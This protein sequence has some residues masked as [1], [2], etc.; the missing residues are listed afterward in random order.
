MP[1]RHVVYWLKTSVIGHNSFK[2][3][4]VFHIAQELGN[5][6]HAYDIIDTYTINK[7][8]YQTQQRVGNQAPLEERPIDFWANL[9]Q[10]DIKSF[11]TLDVYIRLEGMNLSY[12]LNSFSLWHLDF[13][14]LFSC[15]LYLAKTS[16]LFYGILGI[17][18]LFFVFLYLIE[19]ELIYI[20]FSVFGLG[21]FL[22]RAF[23]EFNFSSYVPFPSLVQYNE[24][25]F[26]LS[27]Y[28]TVLGGLF[29]L[30]QYLSIPRNGILI[31]RVIPIYLVMTLT[32]YLCFIFRYSFSEVGSFPMLLTPAPYTF[33]GIFLGMYMVFI[34]PSS[35]KKS[36]IWILLAILPAILGGFLILLNNDAHLTV[37]LPDEWLPNFINKQVIDDILRLGVILLVVTIS[38]NVGYRSLTLKSE[39]EAAIQE[40]LKAQKTIF[41]KQMRTEKLEEMNDLKTRLYTNITH[42]FRTPLTVIMGINDELTE[43]TQKLALPSGKKEKMLQNQQLI[44]RNSE[45]LLNLVNQLLD[46]SKSDS[47]QLELQ[48]IQ[49]NIIPFLNYLTE[50]FFSKAKEKNIRLV[51]YTELSSLMM[52]YDEVKV[53]HLVYN[54]LSNALKFTRENGKIVMHAALIEAKGQSLL[55]LKVKDDGIGIPVDKLPYIFDRFYQVDDSQTRQV[56]GSGIGL[57]FTKDIIHLMDGDI[58]V[59]SKTDIGSTFTVLLPIRNN[60]SIQELSYDPIDSKLISIE[61]IESPDNSQMQDQ[62][63]ILIV[64]DNKDVCYYLEQVLSQSY[65]IFSAPNG[66]IGIQ[67]AKELIPDLIISDVMMPIKDGYELTRTLKSHNS[68]SHIPI[69]LLTAK[70]GQTN[71][72][73]GLRL[74]A[75]A[76]LNKPFNKQELLIRIKKL[77]EIRNAMQQHYAV[78][79]IKTAGHSLAPSE[80]VYIPQEVDFINQLKKIITIHMSNEKLNAD[81]IASD[82]GISQ[83]QLYRKIKA[84]TGLTP[85]SYIRQVR[86]QKSVDLL[87]NTEMDIAQIAYEVGFSSPSYYSRSFHKLFNKSPLIYRKSLI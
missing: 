67:K 75:D 79:I 57:S 2:G 39:K 9:I 26:H 27:V 15:Q 42:E 22:T 14:Y 30:S 45:N 86:L 49:S 66:E 40:N 81:M 52:D 72:Y 21:L 84:V 44:Q 36:K 6:L 46:L 3:K 13:D 43:T 58:T 20:S 38:L 50:S 18:I 82:I 78:S 32:S 63:I 85:N 68:T 70:A 76:Y 69:I 31:K 23:T 53:Q 34:S 5:D 71:K 17:Q 4:Q 1:Q 19:K 10:L 7:Q 83:S 62:A 77:I 73:E 29:F 59:E 54:L 61:Q 56:D 8:G 35:I 60:A 55:Q 47:Q 80:D 16:F 12:P 87:Q 64:E 25:L 51:F 48:L 11:D 65:Q 33:I 24:P 37:A 41:E 74:G 28:I